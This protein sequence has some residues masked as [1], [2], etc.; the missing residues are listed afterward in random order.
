MKLS[1]FL[2]IKGF[3]KTHLGTPDVIFNHILICDLPHLYLLFYTLYSGVN[4]EEISS[5][6]MRK[7]ISKESNVFSYVRLK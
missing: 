3:N 2:F 6:L 5:Q 4:I 1:Y 7:R